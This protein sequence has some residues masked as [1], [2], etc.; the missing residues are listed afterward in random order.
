MPGVVVLA[1]PGVVRRR[2]GR[3]AARVRR[4][5]RRR[6]RE[7]LGRQGRVPVG[8]PA[9]PGDVRAPGPRLRAARVGRRRLHRRHGHR[10]RRVA[11]RAIRARAGRRRRAPRPRAVWPDRSGP[12]ARRPRTS[13]TSVS[14]RS[15]SR[16]TASEQ[17]PLHPARAVADL[18]AAL[19]AGRC[20]R[21]GA[22]GRRPLGRAHLPDAG[23]RSRRAATC[24]RPGAA[25]PGVAARLAVREAERR[26]AGD[27]RERPRA[28]HDAFATSLRRRRAR[29]VRLVR[30]RVAGCRRGSHA[31]R[32]TRSAGR[33]ALHVAGRP[34]STFPSTP[35]R[36]A[37]P[38]RGGG[39]GRGLGR[40]PPTW[41]DAIPLSSV[42]DGRTAGRSRHRCVVG[43]RARD[44]RRAGRP[45]LA[46]RDRRPPRATGSRRPRPR[47]RD[48]GG[49]AF[50]HPLDVSDAGVDHAFLDAAADAL[51]PVEVL[52]NNAGMAV[53]GYLHDVP[54][55]RFAARSRPTSSGRS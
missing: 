7:H 1:G 13:S 31:V 33:P 34:W 38:R 24:R 11:A 9:P 53:P 37:Q 54:A 22:R 55:E 41:L 6:R 45:G 26:P 3:R 27:R 10:R 19:P 51:G 4:G 52:V 23:A 12:T 25:D 17:V 14:P 21:R 50:A 32:T 42:R 48:A 5:R 44:R 15:R 40:P 43:H 49:E 39:R 8:Q 47:S 29:G 35:A 28:A 36:R 46:G 2:C 18:G 30:G 16:D 20:A